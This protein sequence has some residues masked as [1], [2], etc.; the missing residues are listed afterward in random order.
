MLDYPEV[1]VRFMLGGSGGGEKGHPY[2]IKSI[3]WRVAYMLQLPS[4]IQSG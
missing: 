3:Q 1:G 2:G 4:G